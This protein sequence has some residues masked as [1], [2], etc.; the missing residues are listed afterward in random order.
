[1]ERKFNTVP[2]E[3]R[4]ELWNRNAK[5]HSSL[6]E[7]A[8][9]VCGAGFTELFGQPE[10]GK[11]HTPSERFWRYSENLH[12]EKC[13]RCQA[14]GVEITCSSL[15]AKQRHCIVP[16]CMWEQKIK[17]Q[18]RGHALCSLCLVA[19]LKEPGPTG[20]WSMGSWYRV[21]ADC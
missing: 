11:Q 3:K 15:R 21:C 5:R 20:S 16:G 6:S 18:G 17:E 7:L 1:M 10:A 8:S 9:K 2:T 12:D 13:I 19:T 14:R 4:I